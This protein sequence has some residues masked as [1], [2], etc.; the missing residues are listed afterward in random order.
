MMGKR[1]LSIGLAAAMVLTLLTGLAMAQEPA[2]SPLGT[3]FTYQGQLKSNGLP[4]GGSCDFQFGLWDAAS[5]GL[6]IGTT[7]TKT[8]VG[9]AD[10][11]FTVQLDYGTGRFQGDARWLD[12]SVRCPAGGG[13]YTPLTPRQPLTPSPYALFTTAAPWTGLSGVPAGFADGIDNDTTY[14][15]GTG[16][17]LSGTTFSA[18]TTYLQRRVSGTCDAGNAIRVIN[19]DGTVTC[20]PVGGGGSSGWLLT[21]NAGTT[22]GTNYVGTSDNQALEMKVNGMRALRLEPNGQSPNLLLGHSANWATN[23]VYGAALGGGGSGGWPNRVTDAFGTVGGGEDN[24]AGNNLGTV[25]DASY[26]TVGG[27]GANAASGVFSSI[28][29]GEGN[30]AAGAHATVGGGNLNNAANQFATVSGG[31]LN[32]ASF[33]WATVGG[34]QQ[35]TAG[36]YA[37]VGGGG[38]NNG[39][40]ISATIGGGASNSATGYTATVG[41][42]YTNAGGG[43]YSTVA[44]GLGNVASGAIATVPGG[45]Q[46]LAEGYTSFAAGFRA[47]ALGDGSFVWADWTDADYFDAGPN[48]FNVRS[49]GGAH[50]VAD[51]GTAGATINNDLH[52]T[53]GDGLRVYSDVSKGDDWAAVYARNWGTSPALYAWAGG[54]YSGVF[55]TWISVGGCWGC[56]LIEGGQNAGAEALQPGDLAG[57]S[58]LGETLAGSDRPMLRVHRAAPGEAVIGVVYGRGVRTAST[59]EGI[60]FESLD[61]AE[62]DIQPGDYLFLVVY[63][64]AQVKADA[65][66]GAI[67]A[68]TRLTAGG[69][70]GHA[71]ALQTRTIDGMAVAEAAPSVGIALGP[72]DSGTGL[73]PVF[74]TLN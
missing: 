16:L 15:A 31:Q 38:Q 28:G 73:I 1:F 65:S 20:E 61:R 46:N 30:T 69:Q 17:T 57:I 8:N 24:Q 12:I 25:D 49:G 9:V 29:G 53:N 27:G 74:V 70:P 71:R 54:T 48:T 18:N 3:A 34:G 66:S 67:S 63:G 32:T 40:G 44:G 42:G 11:F 41:G 60:S 4:Y 37:T 36:M 35:N 7:Q 47:K 33:Q 64:Q 2:A 39:G 45:N 62:G 51:N 68:G 58:G 52:N 43:N 5:G 6:Q 22:P 59:K 56:L 21:G 14:S 50:I 13:T 26:A 23:G 72:L 10:G 19:A 55:M